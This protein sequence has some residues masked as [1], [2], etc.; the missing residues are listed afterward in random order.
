MHENTFGHVSRINIWWLFKQ[1]KIMSCFLPGWKADDIP[2]P[3]AYPP[4]R[5]RCQGLAVKYSGFTPGR[6]SKIPFAGGSGASSAFAISGS[7]L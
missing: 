1:I 4:Q 7:K 3:A 2:R 6:L 5:L